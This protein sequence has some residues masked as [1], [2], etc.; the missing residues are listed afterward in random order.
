MDDSYLATDC[1]EKTQIRKV[2]SV[3][4]RAICG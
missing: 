2:L 3:K 4:I 1:T